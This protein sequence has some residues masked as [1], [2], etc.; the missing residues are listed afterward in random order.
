MYLTKTELSELIAQ[1]DE[2]DEAVFDALVSTILERSE[3]PFSDSAKK[4]IRAALLNPEFGYVEDFRNA[5]LMGTILQTAA[6]Q[7]GRTKKSTNVLLQ[8]L[9]HGPMTDAAADM[10]LDLD[11][12][13]SIQGSASRMMQGVSKAAMANQV[14]AVTM[15]INAF[16]SWISPLSPLVTFTL[17]LQSGT[18][19]TLVDHAFP[20]NRSWKRGGKSNAKG[21]AKMKLK[22]QTY[23]FRGIYKGAPK[24]VLDHTKIPVSHSNNSNSVAF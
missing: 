13:L 1:P 11:H 18:S 9:A 19:D 23:I 16:S 10:G 4:Q 12:V 15:V 8:Q 14:D 17:T 6:T 21:V 7:A 22:P 5:R 3:Q 2:D 20:N 24:P